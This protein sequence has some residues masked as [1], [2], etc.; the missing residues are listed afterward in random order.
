MA[1]YNL[2]HDDF[3]TRAQES[4]LIS[5]SYPSQAF[6]SRTSKVPYNMKTGI[7]SPASFRAQINRERAVRARL[8]KSISANI[9][10]FSA[11]VAAGNQAFV[12]GLRSNNKG[13]SVF[14]KA[15]HRKLES[16]ILVDFP[17]KLVTSTG[18]PLNVLFISRGESGVGRTLAGERVIADVLKNL[19]AN[20]V[21]VFPSSY[22]SLNT[23]LALALHADVVR[24]LRLFTSFPHILTSSVPRWWGCMARA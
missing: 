7:S 12:S 5:A 23:Q 22:V 9:Y 2:T 4:A 24:E 13:E 17:R 20:V 15:F 1:A 11:S 14:T 21:H 8:Q 3:G 19:G 6:S 16:N 18:R 10:N